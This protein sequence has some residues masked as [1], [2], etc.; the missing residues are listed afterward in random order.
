MAKT[1][2][3]ENFYAVSPEAVWA[4]AKRFDQLEQ[5]SAGSVAYR[6]LPSDPVKQGDVINF[7]VKPFYSSKWNPYTVEM[8]LV[9]DQNMSFVSMEKGAGIKEWKHTMSVVPEGQGARQIDEIYIDAGFLSGL[10]A[11]AAK[12]MYKKRDL[13]RRKILGLA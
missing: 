11:M 6:G 10:V 5:L 13:P 1:I 12:R 9:D 8:E 7:E 3:I 4:A 2:R